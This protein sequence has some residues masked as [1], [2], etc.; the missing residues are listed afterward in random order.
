MQ[1][2]DDQKALSDAAE[3]FRAAFGG[4]ENAVVLKSQKNAFGLYVKYPL[5]IFLC[6]AVV[7]A[8]F[9][10]Q[11]VFSYFDAMYIVCEVVLTAGLAFVIILLVRTWLVV[12]KNAGLAEE[13]TYYNGEVKCLVTTVSG[14]GKKIEWEDAS[15]YING[16]SF[17][18]IESKTKKYNPI[19]YKK[20]HGHSRGYKFFNCDALV[21]TFFGD[22]ATV[23]SDDGRA[24]ELSSGF[25]F[26]IEYG[27][28][29]Y[30]ELTGFYDECYENNFPI[31]SISAQS[32]SYTFRYEF[33]QVNVPNFR[34]ILPD[35]TKECAKLFFAEL[36]EDKN[37]FPN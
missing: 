26:G 6:A 32:K 30:I 8:V 33:T 9:I 11:F 16:D 36:P 13:I 4:I 1:Y 34:L 10:V 15:L 20:I 14:G 27:V 12:I 25:K 35:R 2:L 24:V 29:K 22:N 5:L 37:I 3:R 18:L 21:S 7:A 17:E 23:L 31:L 19:F 28:L